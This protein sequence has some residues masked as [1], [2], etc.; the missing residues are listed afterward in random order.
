MTET[1]WYAAEWRATDKKQY[2]LCSG[3]IDECY[4]MVKRKYKEN[5]KGFYG[6]RTSA[7]FK[8]HD[9]LAPGEESKVEGWKKINRIAETMLKEQGKPEIRLQDSLF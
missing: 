5:P 6:L 4:D 1:T 2:V 9:N 3:T 8:M 7:L